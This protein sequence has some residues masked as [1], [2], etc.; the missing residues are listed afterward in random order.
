MTHFFGYISLLIILSKNILDGRF[1]MCVWHPEADSL[2]FDSEA[3]NIVFRNPCI[4][5]YLSSSRALGIA[6]I[7]GQGKTFLIKAKRKSL[8]ASYILMPKDSVMIDTLDAD[9][10]LPKSKMKFLSSYTNWVSLWKTAIII[11]II[12]NPTIYK[13][14]SNTL[15][16]QF[17]SY[18]KNILQTDNFD[19]RPSVVFYSLIKSDIKSLN[20]IFLDIPL[21]LQALSYIHTPIAIFIDKTDQAF[22]HHIYEILGN[23]DPTV[24]A[25]NASIWQY[26]QLSLANAAYDIFSSTNQHIK[27]YYTIRQEALLDAEDIAPNVYRNFS[28]YI[29]TVEYSKQDLYNMFALYIRHESDANLTIPLLKKTNP[30][31]AFV[32]FDV[33]QHGY[34]EDENLKSEGLF[35][36][37]Y[38]HSMARASDIQQICR[39][40]YLKDVST[41][42]ENMIKHY[43]NESS[44]KIVKQYMAELNPIS[45]VSKESVNDL[46]AGITTNV[47][48]F[49]YM[50]EICRRYMIKRGSK[51]S[52]KMNCPLCNDIYPFA[53]LL[54][55]GLMGYLYQNQSSPNIY[56]QRFVSA[57]KRIIKGGAIVIEK[58]PLYML[59]PCIS[60]LAS[61]IRKSARRNYR[62]TSKIIVG[63]TMTCT[64]K[65]LFEIQTDLEQEK[66]SF[67]EEQVFISSTMKTLGD[68]RKIAEK[69]LINKGY[70]PV[71]CESPDYPIDTH[72]FSHDDCI[73]K[74][75]QCG[76]FITIFD[77]QYGG[78]YS[79]EK[80]KAYADEIREKSQGKIEEPSIT[81]MEYYVARSHGKKFLVLMSNEI[82]RY[83]SSKD[84]LANK[85]KKWA[86]K[87]ELDKMVIT[88]NFINKL[89]L[90]EKD[91]VPNGNMMKFYDDSSDI[92]VCISDHCFN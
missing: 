90:T 23:T 48:D 13:D 64:D 33:L 20:R 70:Y 78:K 34:V 76:S 29:T 22:S 27:V 62:N 67:S 88:M 30:E 9:I 6:G 45:L 54:N 50:R 40:L 38:R 21:L 60:D 56:E 32:G 79:G 44:R 81:L 39:D 4:T 18:T 47:F 35:N 49:D 17:S 42:D 2:R 83:A 58:S 25:R 28:A 31:K 1:N 10:R 69:A 26:S 19:N 82:N 84:Y 55:L 89:R 86:N 12:Q 87:S 3:L 14:I 72:V 75:L 66:K 53:R 11:T 61:S 80:Y 46:L 74:I 8:G 5:S 77:Q 43:I 52:C 92:R 37:M 85:R 24:G 36:Y 63:N 91:A 15:I 59:H 41:L 57:E 51:D 71:I 65:R 68:I 7:K 73:D 16:N